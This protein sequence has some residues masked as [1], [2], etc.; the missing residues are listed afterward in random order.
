ITTAGGLVFIGATTDSM[1]RAFDARTG[2]ML[3]SDTLPASAHTTP[4][5]YVG[6]DGRQY[7]VVGANGGSCFRSPASDEIIAYALPSPGRRTSS[8]R[9][10]RRAG[11][12]VPAFPI[13]ALGS[14]HWSPGS[15]DPGKYSR[16]PGSSDPGK[17]SRSPGS[18]DPG[19][20]PLW[21][22]PIA[23]PP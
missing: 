10:A 4:A 11:P 3:W 23:S 18:L 6:R 22:D 7:V 8:P 9:R 13:G 2:E 20:V 5:T 17:Y 19:K 15:S 21:G 14:S 12:E 1:F 16:S